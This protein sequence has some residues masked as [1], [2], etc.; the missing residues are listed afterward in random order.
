LR[1]KKS[2]TI[3]GI[4]DLENRKEEEMRKLSFIKTELKDPHCPLCE[5][6]LEKEAREALIEKLEASKSDLEA[7]ILENHS[8]LERLKSE[9]QKSLMELKRLES[10]TKNSI[11]LSKELGEKEQNLRESEL[12]SKQ[13]EKAK[14]ELGILTNYIKDKTYIQEFNKTLQ[15]LSKKRSELGYDSDKHTSIKKELEE[16]RKFVA[17]HEILKSDQIKESKYTKELSEL[18]SIIQPIAEKI[19]KK[20]ILWKTERN[21]LKFKQH[22]MSFLMINKITRV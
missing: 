8:D 11:S 20:V 18:Q 6:P 13:L 10:T 22:L 19:K 2:S 5:S 16:Y 14:K 15:N 4:S 9:E 21:S 3:S 7:R 17:E 12:A 1:E